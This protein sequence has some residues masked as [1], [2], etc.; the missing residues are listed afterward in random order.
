MRSVRLIFR[1]LLTALAATMVLSGPASAEHES[2]WNEISKLDVIV[3][4]YRTGVHV[5]TAHQIVTD[6]RILHQ[7]VTFSDEYGQGFLRLEKWLDIPFRLGSDDA[8]MGGK[9]LRG[10][11]AKMMA[12]LGLDATC[13][14]VAREYAGLCDVFVIDRVDA[15]HSDEIEALGMRAEVTDTVMESLADKIDLA[16]H[17]SGLQ[18]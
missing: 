13:V 12:E 14:G 16:R 18:A 1:P 2:G 3:D 6:E 5:D 11:A 9:A 17:I 8:A 7:E 10:P 4:I 15:H